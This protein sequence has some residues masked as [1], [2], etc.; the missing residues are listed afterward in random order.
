MANIFVIIKDVEMR[1]TSIAAYCTVSSDTGR[2]ADIE[3]IGT[4]VTPASNVAQLNASLVAAANTFVTS[5]W[6]LTT[7]GGDKTSL[8]GGFT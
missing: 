6:A 5:A 7:G 4:G 1:A 3:L 8:I 2:K